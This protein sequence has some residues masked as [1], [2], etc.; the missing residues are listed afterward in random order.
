MASTKIFYFTGT[1]NSLFA[2]KQLQ[3]RIPG[4]EIEPMV[5]GLY[6]GI[7]TIKADSV[8]FVFPVYMMSAP[9]PLVRFIEL[10]DLSNVGYVFAVA[11][12]MGLSHG[13]FETVDRM[14][15]KK[16][17][18]LNACFNLQMG[19]NSAKLDYIAPTTEEL[20]KIEALAISELEAIS[21]I[22]ANQEDSREKD[23]TAT[24]KV[25]KILTK[26]AGG[27]AY[28]K[29][30]DLY[31]DENCSGCGTCVKICPAKRIKLIAGKPSWNDGVKCF[32]CAACI[33]Y[34]PSRAAQIRNYTEKSDRY[35]HPYA[36]AD[37][38]FVQ[39]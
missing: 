12:R 15:R 23:T 27:M 26:M 16:H 11:T 36:T 19:N 1:G 25:P 17:K 3:A 31:T 28:I 9:L 8:G 2:A 14:L 20:N 6:E 34:C 4:C 7:G 30:D 32:R 37:D 18:K 35:P 13:A 33:N 5:K 22:I 10:C 39:K 38:I 29:N 24:K 21:K